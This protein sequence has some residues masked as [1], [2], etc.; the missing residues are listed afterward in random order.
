MSIH[1]RYVGQTTAAVLLLP[2]LLGLGIG[3]AA[4]SVITVGAGDFAND[5]ARI[6][7]TGAPLNT[8]DPFYLPGPDQPGAATVAFGGYF[9]GQ[10]IANAAD[11]GTS[12]C[13]SGRPVGTLALDPSAPP[14]FVT[15]ATDAP[16]NP[17]LSGSPLFG[18]PISILFG[19]DQTAVG[20]SVGFTERP[21][22]ERITAFDRDGN[23]LG[24]ALTTEAGYALIGLGNDDGRADIAGLQIER[25]GIADNGFAVDDVVFGALTPR[26]G[27]PPAA[28]VPAPGAGLLFALGVLGMGVLGWRRRRMALAVCPA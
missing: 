2:L 4:A 24:Q 10:G 1:T 22:A 14:T 21:G 7:F 3:P 28:D 12:G 6:D 17:V 9:V 20:V 26:A 16:D 23:L 27:T 25:T 11:C 5:S 18:G 19:V 13:L 15:R 8:A